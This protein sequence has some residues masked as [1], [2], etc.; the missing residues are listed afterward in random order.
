MTTINYYSMNEITLTRIFDMLHKG[1]T[2]KG[3]IDIEGMPKEMHDSFE[4]TKKGE[5]F[6]LF[7]FWKGSFSQD[8]QP[9]SKEPH[10]KE[11]IIAFLQDSFDELTGGK[12][13]IFIKLETSV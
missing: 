13:M 7:V 5:H 8:I 1:E 9:L 11:E 4:I 2:V 10:S 6:E 12:K 3:N